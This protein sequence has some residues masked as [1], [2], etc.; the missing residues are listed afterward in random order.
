MPTYKY[1]P[2]LRWKAGEREALAQ[3]SPAAKANVEPLIL[4]GSEQY[5][6][7]KSPPKKAPKRIPKKAPPPA[8]EAF[9][10]QLVE[11]WGTD[12]SVLL[13][14]SA[15]I[16][17]GSGHHLDRIAQDA[18]KAGLQLMPATMLAVDPKYQAAVRRMV[19]TDHRG[20]ALRVK[21]ADLA[22][23]PTWL[24]S[25]ML[26]PAETDLIIDLGNSVGDVAA[27]G[28]PVLDAFATLHQ[29]A[30]WRSVTLAGS[31]IPQ[32]L[33]GFKIG[34]T[35]LARSELT[36]WRK[37]VAHGLPYRIDFGDYAT[38]APDALTIDVPGSFP[39]NVKYTLKDDFFIR[40][41]VRTAGLGGIERHIQF[42]DHA[43]SIHRLAT[44]GKLADCWG[45]GQIDRIATDPST[46]AGSPAKWVAYSVNRHIE[47]TRAHLP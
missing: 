21:L 16:E 39:I 10:Q 25:W 44:R 22:A 20:A 45:D 46:S 12:G 18:R 6:A 1:T 42:R 34:A 43:K 2:L 38:V 35:T 26:S 17:T 32:M 24:V 37:L 29:G 36:L 33:S 30:S 47:I 5:A 8:H 14:A 23:A 4:L 40:H 19:S 7:T 3:I 13:D 15:L 31:S 28:V 27:L 9:V 41:G 11:T